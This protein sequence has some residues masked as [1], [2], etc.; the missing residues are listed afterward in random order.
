LIIS[1]VRTWEVERVPVG[2]KWI[3]PNR[4]VVSRLF[5]RL[6]YIFVDSGHNWSVPGIY[7]FRAASDQQ[8]K[9]GQAKPTQNNVSFCFC[10][11]LITKY[12][13]LI[14]GA[15]ASKGAAAVVEKKDLPIDTTREVKEGNPNLPERVTG[16]ADAA[17]ERE[18]GTKEE[19]DVNE[20]VS[21]SSF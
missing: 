19:A 9:S 14:M 13:Y 21:T 10:T 8:R 20:M 11:R 7:L 5:R 15:C 1:L 18:D 17:G 4:I 3:R 6:P 12:Q 16:T 2:G